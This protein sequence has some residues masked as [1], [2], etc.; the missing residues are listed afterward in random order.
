MYCYLSLFH[1]K[2]KDAE[3]LN[4]MG[5]RAILSERVGGKKDTVDTLMVRQ[6]LFS[7]N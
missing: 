3:L 1:L 6:M 5:F 2:D 7:L 4:E